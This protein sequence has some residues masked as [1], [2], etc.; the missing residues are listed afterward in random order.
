MAKTNWYGLTAT[1]HYPYRIS[2]FALG[3]SLISLFSMALHI[4]C[5][6]SSC[7]TYSFI[8]VR[9]KQMKSSPAR[10][11]HWINQCTKSKRISFSL[12]FFQSLY[13]YN[14]LYSCLICEQML[15]GFFY[16]NICQELTSVPAAASQEEKKGSRRG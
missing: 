13:L 6:K 15:I 4:T 16:E 14:H 7:F 2:P 10:N 3:L 12:F 1:H 8:F 9:I 11:N 5:F